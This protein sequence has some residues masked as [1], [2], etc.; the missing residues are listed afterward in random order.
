MDES[1]I[2]D[3]WN[4]YPCGDL[5]IGGFK[6]YRG[7][8]EKFFTDYDNFR[9]L[10]E[11]HILHCLDNIDFRNKNVLEIGLGQ[12]ADSEQII[13]RGAIWSGLDLTPES[14]ERVRLR[15]QLRQLSHQ[16]LK[17]GSVLK[18]PYEDNT[19]DIVFSHGV[20]HHVPDID[21][22]QR[23]IWRVLK[24]DGELIVMLY[25]KWSLNYLISI[26]IARRLGL[27]ALYIANSDP[28][29][30][31]SQHLANARKMG[32]LRYLSMSNFIHRNTDGPFNPYSKV[33]DLSTVRRDFAS[34][35]VVRAYRRFMPAPPPSGRTITA[36]QGVGLEPLGSHEA[37][38]EG[39]KLIT[40][41]QIDVNIFSG[42]LP[43]HRSTRCRNGQKMNKHYL[44]HTVLR[45]RRID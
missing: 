29:G 33:Y 17:Q 20:L 40:E 19:F 14:V 44:E 3:F 28:G 1:Q 5:L 15:L 2:Q 22:A 21:R 12:G 23:E 31:Y 16:A 42:C 10:K 9:Y 8:Y 45:T 11:G 4:R 43:L 34:F 36:R 24:P 13:R 30:V 27:L 38:A 37:R 26:G 6:E 25:A 39:L 35:K 41:S 7:D 18:I 32:I